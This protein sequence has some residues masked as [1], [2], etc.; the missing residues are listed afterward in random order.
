VP[1][2]LTSGCKETCSRVGWVAAR[3]GPDLMLSCL[4]VQYALS[5]TAVVKA[6]GAAGCAALE[7]EVKEAGSAA[8][9]AAGSWQQRLQEFFDECGTP[10]ERAE[11]AQKVVAD[12]L[13]GCS[14]T[15]K[16]AIISRLRRQARGPTGGAPP[17]LVGRCRLTVSKPVLKAPLVSALETKM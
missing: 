13:E 17:A 14:V 7:K 12:C 1:Q 15:E 11:R 2:A 16:E 8:A 6:L 4:G 3:D 5:D 10:R 9:R